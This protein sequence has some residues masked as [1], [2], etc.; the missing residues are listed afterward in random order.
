ME[1]NTQTNQ[2]VQQ[3]NPVPQ[4]KPP[5]RSKKKKNLGLCNQELLKLVG[6][7]SAII[8]EILRLKDY[9]PE[10][11]SNKEEEK[12]YK[13][14]IYDFTY[15]KSGIRDKFEEKLHSNQSLLDMDEDFRT[16][17]I[18]IIER[19]FSLFYSIFQY[20]TDWKSFLEQVNQGRFVQHTL[21][22]IITNKELRPIFCESLFSIGVMLLLVDKL[23][24]GPI[25]EKIIVSYY[26]YKGQTTITNFDSI[27]KIFKDTS[28]IPP[29]SFSDPKDEKKPSKYPIDFF[30]RC[31]LPHQII[32]NT[33]GILKDNDIYEQTL[34]FPSPEHRSHAL[35]SQAAILVIA[36]FFCPQILEKDQSKMREIV[37][38]HFNDNWVISIYMGYTID[39]QDYWKEFKAANKALEFCLDE[40][41][42]KE[43]KT[44]NYNKLKDM[45]QQVK[46]YL[47]EGIMTEEFVLKDIENLLA[48]LRQSNV[49][50]RWFILQRNINHKK[51][52]Q[53]FNEGFIHSDIIH[54]LLNLSQFEYLLKKM[55]TTL[56]NNKEQLWKTDKEKCLQKL[57]Q[58]VSYYSGNTAFSQDVKLENYSKYFEETSKKI[59]DLNYNNPTRT[60]KKIGQIR[61]EIDDI[62]KL[63]NISGAAFATQNINEINDT[64]NHMLLILNVKKNYLVYIA[65]IS[66]FS[67]AWISIQDYCDE[68]RNELKN[69]SK[70]VLLLRAT[71]LKLASI[72]NFPLVRLFEIESDDIDSVTN[73]YSGELVKFVKDILQIIPQSV[74][75]ILSHISDIFSSGF[76][77]IP[78]KL[79]KI[80]IKNYIQEE[81]RFDL[82]QSVH[83]ISM[84]T[85]GIYLMEKTLMGV[86]EVDPKII[87]EEGIRKELLRLLA[88]VYHN[89]INF[90]PDDKIDISSKLEEL[91][92][93]IKSLKKS[94]IY[95]QDYININGSKMWCEE[96]H[97]LINY[98]VEIEANKFLKKKIKIKEEEQE[99]QRYLLAFISPLKNSPQSRTFLGRLMNYVISLTNPKKSWFCPANYIWYDLSTKKNEIFG[100]RTI[101]KIKEAIGIEGFQGFGKL[102]GYYNYQNILN[103]PIYYNQITSIP[104]INTL[105]KNISQEFGN[106]FVIKFKNKEKDYKNLLYR[107]ESFDNRISQEIFDRILKIGQIEFLRKLQNFSLSENSEVEAYILSSQIK[108]MNEI[109]LL[110]LKNNINLKFNDPAI[111]QDPNNQNAE[112]VARE[113]VKKINNYYNDLCSFLEDF[114]LVDTQHTFY[115]NLTSLQYLPL[116]ITISVYN[117]FKNYFHLDRKNCTL[118]KKDGMGFDLYY[119]TLGVYCI[120]YQMGK[121]NIILFIALL[122]F[123]MRTNLINLFGLKSGKSTI[124]DTNPETSKIIA[125]IQLFLQELAAN[126]RID[127]NY[128]EINFNSYLIFRNIIDTENKI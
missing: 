95:I 120:L 37:D 57:S 1:I 23:I 113:Q 68:M 97:K 66:D 58:L 52:R 128:F 2:P 62:R 63:W 87:L 104:N 121:N 122:S 54:L 17:N 94:F 83:K 85:K 30:S 111:N 64:L 108:S 115:C 22:N 16:N 12:I 76:K 50:L 81:K 4:E 55:F 80:E 42:L 118:K 117:Q 116:L 56:V 123:L 70:K 10:A 35:S 65:K 90:G 53:L 100:I 79:P 112:E 31:E 3:T 86:I 74:F 105:L 13:E 61:E 9:I 51:Y 119:F 101:N 44:K 6:R 92:N 34:A 103:M 125:I 49:A 75:Q 109:N 96:M 5:K 84:F 102:L 36:L 14:I 29:T 60:G 26:R 38:K 48:I 43:I 124:V 15:F 11:Y 33:I 88:Y 40:T 93:K 19:F 7:G 99:L 18:E 8:C 72:L 77:E 71:F 127:L 24:P 107:I 46:K 28:Y 98:Y 41:M 82:A 32:E 45:T 106:P 91:I 25:R 89:M 114:G 67:Y 47:N 78:L 126:T 21:D 20:I 59:N 73:Y 69:D 39:I 110:I 27:F